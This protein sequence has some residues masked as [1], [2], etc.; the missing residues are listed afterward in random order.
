[1]DNNGQ[2]LGQNYLERGNGDQGKTQEEQDKRPRVVKQKRRWTHED[3]NGQ[4]LGQNCL[5]Q[6][7]GDQGKTVSI[8]LFDDSDNNLISLFILECR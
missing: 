3:E 8:K 6:G 7:N 2:D 4:D 1:M 5:E